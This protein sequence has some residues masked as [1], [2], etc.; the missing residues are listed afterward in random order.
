MCV[1]VCVCMCVCIS[2]SISISAH[3]D[4]H[5]RPHRRDEQVEEEVVLPQDEPLEVE[6]D[7]AHGD[8]RG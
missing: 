8:E 7:V 5:A 4:E 3:R 6:R 2:I 1:C